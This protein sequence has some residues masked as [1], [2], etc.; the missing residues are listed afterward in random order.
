MDT[1][2]FVNHLRDIRPGEYLSLYFRTPRTRNQHVVTLLQL[3]QHHGLKASIT[4]EEPKSI[5]DQNVILLLHHELV[6]R[7]IRRH[8]LWELD[9]KVRLFT[10]SSYPIKLPQTVT[11]D[12]FDHQINPLLDEADLF[13]YLTRA[14]GDIRLLAH[15]FDTLDNIDDLPHKY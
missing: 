2:S 4:L 3:P 14:T 7:G 15:L 11:E 10:L 8:T 13:I 9:E 12:E 5:R 1:S 6:K